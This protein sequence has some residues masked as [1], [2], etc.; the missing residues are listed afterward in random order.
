LKNRL[1]LLD[2]VLLALVVVL[3]M[4][5]RQNWLEA[6]KRADI[7][8]GRP[9]PRLATP[10]HSPLPAVEPVTAA[11]YGVIAQQ[12][13]FS[14]DRNP[15]VIVE[16]APPKPMPALPVL[17]G[18]MDL[19]NGP[20]AIMSEKSG[21]DQREVRSGGTIGEFKLVAVSGPNIVLEWDGQKVSRRVAELMEKAVAPRPEAA[22]VTSTNVSGPGADAGG[23]IKVCQ[24]GDNSP[25]GAVVDGYRK[26]FIDTPFGKSC[27]W[28]AVK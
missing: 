25:A 6:R 13:L 17:Y 1:L 23:G 11:Q 16:I 3:G 24:I 19:G 15:T 27:R 9:V 4:R 10:P 5:L 20:V 7:V 26:T 22:S 12:T 14:S 18:V 28:E 21:A 8:L 2:L